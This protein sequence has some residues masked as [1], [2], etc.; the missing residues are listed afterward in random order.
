MVKASIDF[1]KAIAHAL[2]CTVEI[3]DECGTGAGCILHTGGLVITGRHV[4]NNTDGTSRRRVKVVLNPGLESQETVDGN[5]FYSHRALDLALLWLDKPGPY[6]AIPIGDPSAVKHAQTVYAIGSPGSLANTLSKGIV[7]NPRGKFNGIECIQTDAA[8]D[9]GN[10]GGPLI[11]AQGELLGI[12][13]WG[14]GQFDA[15]KFAVPV[16]YLQA[17]ISQA[18]KNGRDVS[19]EGYYC[20][21]CG[22]NDRKHNGSFCV[23]CGAPFEKSDDDYTLGGKAK[24]EDEEESQ[25]SMEMVMQVFKSCEFL[26]EKI[27]RIWKQEVTYKDQSGFLA[28]VQTES[29]AYLFASSMPVM[30]LPY[31][32]KTLNMGEVLQ[33]TS[34]IGEIP[35][36]RFMI[37][38][39]Q[40]IMLQICAGFTDLDEE[41]ILQVLDDMLK[42]FGGVAEDLHQAFDT[43]F[44][45]SP[46]DRKDFPE[47]KLPNIPLRPD[48]MEVV[49][50]VMA[51]CDGHAQE[52]FRYLMEHWHKSGF[53]VSSTG[54]MIVLDAPYG[55]RKARLAMLFPVSANFKKPSIGLFWDKLRLYKGFPLKAVDRYQESVKKIAKISKVTNSAAYILADEKMTT[56]Q[57]GELVKAMKTLVESINPENIEA[58]STSKPVTPDNLNATLEVCDESTRQI[59]QLLVNGWEAA[60]GTVQCA[61]Q[62]RIYLRLKTKA[63]KSGS[64]ARVTRNF[65]LAVLAAPN[66]KT[67]ANIQVTFGL[68]DSNSQTAYLDC[69][70]QEVAEFETEVSKMPG[71][72]RHGTIERIMLGNGFTLKHA[73]QLMKGMLTLKLAEEKTD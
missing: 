36:S 14:L 39:N 28:V 40:V 51:G 1:E 54:Q 3:K 56:K 8:I 45:G 7:C 52:I 30:V 42:V 68:A 15:A 61:K 67:P 17:V 16:D 32:G 33:L 49:K 21:H 27:D 12:N 65:N 2:S 29:G 62:G 13:L 72:E 10:S 6:P 50:H 5:V 70:P 11:N 58:S 53:T 60:G 41:H 44:L 25:R 4:V 48:E 66:G 64:A 46:L 18:L 26:T 35:H 19:L 47:P 9:H 59:F 73:K 69:I 57:V 34:S 23:N 22:F 31:K 55:E 37:E 20:V 24:E 38:N 71:F 63:H 43:L